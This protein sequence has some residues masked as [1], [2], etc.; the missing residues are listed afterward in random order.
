MKM[1]FDAIFVAV[2]IIL[3]AGAVDA[4]PAHQAFIENRVAI[5]SR[6]VSVVED[7]VFTVGRAKSS[8][9][10]GDD[11][12]YSKAAMFAYDNLDRLNFERAAWPEDVTMAEKSKAWR[13]YRS[14]NPFLLTIEGGQRIYQENSQPDRYLV[15]MSFPK[16][17]VLLPP[18]ETNV[19][20]PIIERFRA[21]VSVHETPHSVDSRLDPIRG[22]TIL[23][24]SDEQEVKIIE[25][26]DED[27][28]L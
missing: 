9:T 20:R 7:Y 6:P 17:A 1:R 21:E 22:A 26:F 11:I 15:V 14:G 3:L 16:E 4:V 27:L 23:H 8:P 19:L 13:V 2:G 5:L 18:V 28:F 25:N 12:G 10:A 24:L